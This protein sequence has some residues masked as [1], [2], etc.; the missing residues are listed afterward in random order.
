MQKKT[1]DIVVVGGGIHG[2]GI[3]QA[4]AARGHSV[5]ALEKNSLACETSSRSSKLIHGGLRYLE[6]AQFRL[7][8][9]CLR[10]RALLL[11]LAPDLVKL[12]PFYIP[13]YSETTRR[14]WQLRLGLSLYNLLD[15]FSATSR[16][17]RFSFREWDNPDGLNT[18]NLTQIF[19]YWDA[20]TD[21]AALTRAVMKSA[22][23]MG[24]Y[25]AMPATFD[26]AELIADGCEVQ[27]QHKGQTCT[28]TCHTLVNAAGPWANTL[29][30]SITPQPNRLSMDLVQ[31]SHIVV[32][33]A[34]SKGFYYLEA[35]QDKR[36][37]FAMPWSGKILVG[38]TEKI[39]RGDPA[40]VAPT[41]EEILYL[42]DTLGHYFP[43]FRH[44]QPDQIS[45]AFAGL[46][47]IPSDKKQP[48]LRSRETI[49]HPDRLTQPRVLTIYGGKLTAYRATAEKVMRKL[50]NSLPT[51][52]S[53]ADTRYIVLT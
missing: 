20:Q 2:A 32:A 33:G 41:D 23:N 12:H 17:R 49:L 25:L 51:H 28:C 52:T 1:Y 36:A 48:F 24:A 42:L 19:Q 50:E 9:E 30:E 29:L 46:R 34:L 4:A 38:T 53:I 47:V 7:V 45:A 22:E 16:Y 10:E 8:H 18:D 37:V 40:T 6:T 11:K 31:G 21:D 44:L 13:I 3:A 26:C 35:P 15:G 5:L 27:Y 14:P 39:F 43:A